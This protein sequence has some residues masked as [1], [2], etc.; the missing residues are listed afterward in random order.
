MDKQCSV[1]RKRDTTTNYAGSSA[2]VDRGDC[3]ARST[4]RNTIAGNRKS[5]HNSSKSIM[6]GPAAYGSR[7]SDSSDNGEETF[8]VPTRPRSSSSSNA[9]DGGAEED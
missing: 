9:Y 8:F 5:I 1:F 2:Y 7:C 3:D 6:S 4:R